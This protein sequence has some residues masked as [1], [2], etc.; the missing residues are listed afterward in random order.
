MIHQIVSFPEKDLILF[1]ELI[2]KFQGKAE[3]DLNH[4]LEIP[5]WHKAETLKRVANSNPEN[6]LDWELVKNNFKMV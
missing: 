1:Q 2:K 3:N 4:D 6:L 5:E